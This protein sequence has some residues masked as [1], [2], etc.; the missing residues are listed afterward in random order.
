MNFEA[1]V[2]RES[3][4]VR[5]YPSVQRF[6]EVF[7]NKLVSELAHFVDDQLDVAA[8]LVVVAVDDGRPDL[9][10]HSFRSVRL[11]GS[12]QAVVV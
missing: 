8:D 2:V 10:K 3:D 9:S 4:V 7:V 6:V 1:F 12:F 5:E 11:D